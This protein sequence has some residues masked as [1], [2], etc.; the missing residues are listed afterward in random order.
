[1]SD[2]GWSSLVETCRAG[3]PQV[4]LVNQA[5]AR[6]D[7]PDENP[8]ARSVYVGRDATPWEIVGIV[9]DV[10]QFGFDR[11]AEPQ[12]FADL[13]QWSGGGTLLFPLGAYYAV[14]TDG[15]PAAVISNVRRIVSEF[16]VQA[17]LF[18]V[19]SMDELV[20]ATISRPRLYAVLAGMFAAIGVVLAA[21]GIYGVMAYLVSQRTREIGIRVALGAIRSE[22]VMLVLGRTPAAASFRNARR[23]SLCL[24]MKPAP[25]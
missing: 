18:N 7:F 22:V 12:F 25:V 1:M 5:L 23:S 11:E 13:H 4:L 21:I 19:T 20:A 14:R 8:V 3:Q 17:A 15:D 16:D 9:D 10:R 24:F 2:V 6:R